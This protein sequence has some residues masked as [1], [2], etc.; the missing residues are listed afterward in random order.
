VAFY[1][2]Y[3]HWPVVGRHTCDNPRCC[4]PAHILD[5][6]HADNRRDSVERGRYQHGATHWMA[7]IDAAAVVEIRRRRALGEPLKSI[8]DD[9]GVTI[10]HVH[11]I[12]TRR[13]W[14]HVP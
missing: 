5:G 7:K 4:N 10:A 2:T 9:F 3:G 14:K 1:L 11:N 8:A 6:T 13:T 12:Y